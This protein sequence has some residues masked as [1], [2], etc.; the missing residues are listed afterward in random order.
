[1]KEKAL[2]CHICSST[3]I[4]KVTGFEHLYRVTSDC[5]PWYRGG[6]LCICR[7]CSSVQKIID[8]AWQAEVSKIYQSYSIYHQSNGAEQVIFNIGSEMGVPRSM[9]LLEYLLSAVELPKKGRLMDVGCGNGALLSSFSQK[10]P[11]WSLV[12]TE[13]NG[14]YALQIEKIKQVEK[15]YTGVP[16]DVAGTFDVITLVHLLEHVQN[17]KAFLLDLQK[18]L[19]PDGLLVI[20]IPN[21]LQN[22]F[23]LLVAD[24]CTHFNMKTAEAL[25][26]NAGYQ[27]ISI[28]DKW[29]PREISIIVKKSSRTGESL[30]VDDNIVQA[31]TTRIKWLEKTKNLALDMLN[32]DNVGIF[33][34][35]IAATWLSCELGNRESYFVDEDLHRV[36]KIHLD[37]PI[38]HPKDLADNNNVFIVAPSATATSIKDR[39]H[40]SKYNFK[41]HLPTDIELL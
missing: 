32:Q 37:K 2:S 15:L 33:G 35:S 13:L 3:S 17:P 12:G 26:V 9:Q 24:H 29:I 5:G 41:M 19:N 34:T 39:F 1:M 14:K 4:Q 22:P 8:E 36:G 40:A 30:T 7:H 27:I 38:Y 6:Q 18:K 10:M 21:Y 31:V 28:T 25:L 11:D 16:E 23:D 20:E